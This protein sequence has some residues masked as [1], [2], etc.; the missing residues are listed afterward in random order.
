MV[1]VNRGP[2]SDDAHTSRSS[3]K[4]ADGEI[5]LSKHVSI[6]TSVAITIFLIL[7]GITIGVAIAVRSHFDAESQE[8]L[9]K[10]VEGAYAALQENINEN[11]AKL[12]TIQGLFNATPDVSRNQFRTFVSLFFSDERGTQALEWI[13]RVTREQRE[14]FIRAVREEGFEEFTIHPPTDLEESFPVSYVFPFEPNRAAFGFDLAS[15]ESRLAALG[16]ARDSG[17]L[18][19]TAPITLVQETEEQAGFLVFAPIYST[20][21]IP[22]TL[23]QRRETLSGFGLAVF[24]V[25]DFVDDAIP[26]FSQADFNLEVMD[27]AEGS[28][29][30][31]IYPTQP[32]TPIYSRV[33]ESLLTKL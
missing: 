18:L 33:K 26:A 28:A 25:N 16:Q 12:T 14:E 1:S 8:A 17:A 5:M 10:V 9:D 2:N 15:N 4:Q 21:D 13:P 24:R 20:G 11:L 29:G 22:T 31:L 23:R 27:S 30:T 3:G 19:A 32:P 6:Q 7:F